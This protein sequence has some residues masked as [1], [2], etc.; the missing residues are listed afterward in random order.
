M[1]HKLFS[2]MGLIFLENEKNSIS[3]VFTVLPKHIEIKSLLSFKS[4]CDRVVETSGH[5]PALTSYN[6]LIR[7]SSPDGVRFI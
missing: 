5:S 6:R 4:L 1:V 3:F 7:G 2:P